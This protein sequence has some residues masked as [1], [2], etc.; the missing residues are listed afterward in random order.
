MND[1]E[2]RAMTELSL[3]QYFSKQEEARMANPNS[4]PVK[5][6]KESKHKNG[7]GKMTPQGRMDAEAG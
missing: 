3:Q 7:P 1:Q 4:T 6:A 5:P 2:T